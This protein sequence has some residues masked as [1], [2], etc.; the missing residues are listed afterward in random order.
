MANWFETNLKRF[1]GQVSLSERLSKHT[2][3][4]IGGPASVIVIPKSI[5]D[6]EL[7][8]E[9]IKETGL[10]FFF[11][12]L[13]SNVLV[14][15]HGYKGIVIK[16]TKLNQAIEKEKDKSEIVTGS[17]VAVSSFLRKAEVEGWGGLEF[18]T[19]IPGTVGG[20]TWMNAGTHLGEAKDR[21]RKVEAYEMGDQLRKVEFAGPDLKYSYRRN[22][23]LKSYMLV[24]AVTWKIDLTAPAQVKEIITTTLQRR[25]ETQPLDRPSCGSVF[26]NPKSSGL[27]AWQVIEKLGLRGYRIGDAQ[28]SEKHCN[29]IL[30][31]AQ[32]KASDVR[33]LIDL[34]KKKA[35]DELGIQLEEEVVYVD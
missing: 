17:S 6:L 7:I 10:P 24:Y 1:Q 11:L 3:F 34:A 12:G 33:S 29:F 30:N 31:L 19:G 32:A 4:R 21:I 8:C 28:F 35:S 26:K 20:V 9:G 22:H 14:S 27:S 13:G 5:T 15:D 16:T 25:K 2:Y 23:F 18:L